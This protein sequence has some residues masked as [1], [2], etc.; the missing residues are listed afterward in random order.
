MREGNYERKHN[1]PIKPP[2]LVKNGAS[3]KEEI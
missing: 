2:S 1:Q 3:D